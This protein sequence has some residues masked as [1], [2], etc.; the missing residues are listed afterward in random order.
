MLPA[1]CL[2]LLA[3][4]GAEPLP[5]PDALTLLGVDATEGAAAGYVADEVCAACHAGIYE[6]YQRVGMAR[7][8][9]SAAS[10]DRIEDFGREFFH[11]PSERYYRIDE[12]GDEL[13]FSR[14][15]RTRDGQPINEIRI[16][17]DWVVGSGNRARSYLYQ[18]GWGELYLLPLG[19]YAEDEAWGMSPGFEPRNHPGVNR[20]VSRRCMFC[21]N[22]FPEVPEGADISGMPQR[23]PAELP[24]GTGCQR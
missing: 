14:Y 24:H 11:A 8:F 9:A 4:S 16:S 5:N 20:R 6:S 15:Q 3:R 19:W 21:H 22:A 23:F 10:V 12:H 7:S 17:V 18:T 13:T 1:A 2:L